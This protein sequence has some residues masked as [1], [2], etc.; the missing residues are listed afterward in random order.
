[1]NCIDF[2]NWAI[3]SLYSLTSLFL[4]LWRPVS[5]FC[6]TYLFLKT[7]FTY[8]FSCLPYLITFLCPSLLSYSFFS[9]MK[10]L[11]LQHSWLSIISVGLLVCHCQLPENSLR[12]LTMSSVSMSWQRN[13]TYL[14]LRK[15]FLDEWINYDILWPNAF[16]YVYYY[17]LLKSITSFFPRYL[18]VHARIHRPATSDY[19][20]N[21]ANRNKIANIVCK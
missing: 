12:A 10:K 8:L 7:H 5:S 1:M 6:L 19:S 15:V 16:L 4:G 11:Q 17:L 14:S 18:C 13:G 21:N 9:M 3:F 20:Y 2:P